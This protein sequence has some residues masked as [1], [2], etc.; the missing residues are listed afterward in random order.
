[1]HFIG[2]LVFGF[3]A[4]GIARL[5]MPGH[6]PLGCFITSLLGIAGSFVGGLIGSIIHG[7]PMTIGEPSGWIGSIVGAVVILF[8]YG[9]FAKPPAEPPAM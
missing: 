8:L 3:V 7:G 2:W 1:M 9:K 6:Q 4:G 5:L